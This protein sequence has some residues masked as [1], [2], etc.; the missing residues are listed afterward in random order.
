MKSKAQ[1]LDATA[2]NRLMWSNKNHPGILFID[3]E[4]ELEFVPDRFLDCTQTD[5]P[6]NYF[7]T[8]FFD[9]PHT[10]GIPKNK[11]I[12]TIP[13]KKIAD[14]L[15]NYNRKYPSYYG[16]D[17]FKTKTALLGF[18][19]KAQLEFQRILY[20]YG[21][22]WVKWSEYSIPIDNIKPFFRDWIEML[23]LPLKRSPRGKT[24]S[25]WL[26][27]MKKSEIATNSSKEAAT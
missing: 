7:Y 10:W 20:D 9:P 12:F 16:L 21:M 23:E 5:F 1:I 6:D 22:L 13:S 24:D 19:H 26:M 4:E 15:F 18:I 3:I 11:R 8:I 25:Y 27:Y 2:G 17:K 14:E